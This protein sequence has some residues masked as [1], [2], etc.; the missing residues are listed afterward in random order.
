VLNRRR[1]LQGGATLL[2]VASGGRVARAAPR[3]APVIDSEVR[4]AIA[5][6]PARVLVELRLP[7]PAPPAGS[8]R[9]QAV[10]TARRAVLARLVGTSY[11]LARQYTSIPLLALEIGPDALQA[12][13]G[14][15]DLVAR[16]RADQIHPP[17]APR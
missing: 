8:S 2:L 16:V 5:R 11:R 7:G 15:G 17:A 13:E 3:D 4:A 10:A 1:L 6:G 9:E 14:M 12:L